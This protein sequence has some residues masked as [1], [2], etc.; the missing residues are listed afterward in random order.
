MTATLAMNST[1]MRASVLLL[2]LASDEMEDATQLSIGVAPAG[3][4]LDRGGRR[5]L[6]GVVGVQ[7]GAAELE[8]VDEQP[9]AIPAQRRHAA[10]SY[11]LAEFFDGVGSRRQPE[12]AD[13]GPRIERRERVV[14]PA[15]QGRAH[16]RR[17]GVAR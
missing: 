5:D 11:L 1:F 8:P 12:Y 14:P 15:F 17:V 9:H 10:T 6:L 2:L 16:R 4:E 7:H 3:F 13:L